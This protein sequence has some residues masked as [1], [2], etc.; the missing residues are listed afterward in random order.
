MNLD[1]RIKKI[2]DIQTCVTADTSCIGEEGYFSYDLFSFQNLDDCH[3]AKL[4]DIN[5]NY[6]ESCFYT[7]D[8]GCYSEL[9]QFCADKRTIYKYFLPV[10]CIRQSKSDKEIVYVK[11]YGDMYAVKD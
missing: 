6:A 5:Y 4:V 3:Y 9:K 1:S 8:N 2:S 11:I 7:Y 10:K